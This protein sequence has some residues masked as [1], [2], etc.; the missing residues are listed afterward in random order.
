VSVLTAALRIESILRKRI[1][2]GALPPGS[3]IDQSGIARELGV[4]R[5]PVR[6]ALMTLAAD[7]LVSTT[8]HRGTVVVEIDH[9]GL[10]ELYELRMALEPAAAARA[11]P[12]VDEAC[13]GRM[14][15]LIEMM[16]SVT[17]PLQWRDLND[18]FHALLL[19]RSGRP[20][21]IEI[22]ESARARCG[23]VW[24]FDSACM[25]AAQS[26]H[27]LILGAAARRDAVGVRLLMEAH[28]AL[29]HGQSVK[30]SGAPVAPSVGSP[31]TSST[32]TQ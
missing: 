4:S 31:P 17:D 7:G 3:R 14:A 20:R 12:H 18:E 11:V 30:L 28:L 19:A 24:L 13:T 8:P 29:G 2:D 25:A 26:D 10:V 15:T 5:L 6:D 22:I 21:T 9:H 23:A 1:L 27:R 32:G 16:E